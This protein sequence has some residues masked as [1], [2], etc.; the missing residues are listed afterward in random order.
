VQLS[1]RKNIDIDAP[2]KLAIIGIY[3]KLGNLGW[4][5]GCY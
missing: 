2:R 5:G 1:Y 4:S 3:G